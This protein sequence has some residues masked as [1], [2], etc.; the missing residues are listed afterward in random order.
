MISVSITFNIPL[1]SEKYQQKNLHHSLTQKG[2]NDRLKFSVLVPNLFI[3]LCSD[4]R[5]VNPVI[6]NI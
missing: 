1:F 3:F 2:K 6:I 4:S 5:F